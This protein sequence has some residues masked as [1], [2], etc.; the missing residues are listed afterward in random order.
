MSQ[1]K[2]Y[3]NEIAISF[4]IRLPIPLHDVIE[5]E[6]YKNHRSVNQEIVSRI[7]KNLGELNLDLEEGSK[8]SLY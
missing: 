2:F 6:A 4:S 1:K 7:E 8:E 5:N 3:K